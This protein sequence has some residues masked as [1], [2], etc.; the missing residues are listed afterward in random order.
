MQLSDLHYDDYF[1]VV[2]LR[3]AVNLVNGLQPD[4]VVV[5]GDFIT[6][7]F[8]R[9]HRSLEVRAARAIE[10]CA[11]LLAQIRARFGILAAL[12]NHDVSTDPAHI[13]D[14]LESHGISVLRNRSVPLER[15]G[16]RLWLCGL[17]DILEG[18]P[19]LKLALRGIPQTEPVVLLAHE[20]DYAGY[21]CPCGSAAF[22][23]L[24]RRSNTH[25]A[26]RRSFSAGDGTKISLG[27]TTDWTSHLVHQLRNWHDLDPHASQLSSRS[28][29]DHSSKGLGGCDCAA[30]RLM[31]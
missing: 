17:D 16:G 28:Y 22:R 4:L 9:S 6:A 21:V 29:A 2:P 25:S 13:S 3:K 30:K 27:T 24:A 11:Q 10:P 15:E 23:P 19:D 7:P 31:S 12:G 1:S 26:G 20:P 18:K 5:T 8:L 14:V